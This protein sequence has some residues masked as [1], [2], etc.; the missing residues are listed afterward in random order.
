MRRLASALT[1]TAVLLSVLVVPG[2]AAAR[3]TCC[4]TTPCH[5]VVMACCGADRVPAAA[6]AQVAGTCDRSSNV[7]KGTPA[8]AVQELLDAVTVSARGIVHAA[9]PHG[10][11]SFDLPT[12]HAVLLI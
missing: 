11:R 1:G 8:T 7:D 4:Q 10:F 5:A 2:A 6:P 12:L 3:P 9:P